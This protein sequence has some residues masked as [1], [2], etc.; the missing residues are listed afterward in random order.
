MLLPILLP[1]LLTILLRKLIRG[2]HRCALQNFVKFEP[3]LKTL[4]TSTTI[5]LLCFSLSPLTPLRI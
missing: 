5:K 2:L 4:K 3:C 1:I